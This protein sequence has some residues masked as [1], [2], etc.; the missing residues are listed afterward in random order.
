MTQLKIYHSCK[1]YN[2]LWK[3]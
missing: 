2:S 1:R 3:S